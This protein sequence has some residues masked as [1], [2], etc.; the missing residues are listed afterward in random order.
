VLLPR[1]CARV[2]LLQTL[3]LAAALLVL[4]TVWLRDLSLLSFLSV[5][6]IF[7]SLALLVLVGWEGVTVT[8]FTHDQPP[9]V[10]WPGVPLTLSLYC[11]CFSGHAVFPS[12]YSS[13][14]NKEQFATIIAG[15]FGCVVLIY[16]AMAVLG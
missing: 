13:L 5:G 1:C 12:L 9:L 16:G 3:I 2:L 11:F 6:G 14:R 15:T 4:P 8:G 10:M 7:A